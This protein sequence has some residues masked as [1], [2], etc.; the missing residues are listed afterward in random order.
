MSSDGCSLTVHERIAS[1]SS[2]PHGF[3]RDGRRVLSQQCWQG[4]RAEGTGSELSPAPSTFL[5]RSL[6]VVFLP[7]GSCP[8][9]SEFLLV[10]LGR[11]KAK[12]YQENEPHH[13]H[14]CPQHVL[15]CQ[16]RSTW[17]A[18]GTCQ[19]NPALPEPAWSLCSFC[20]SNSVNK[21]AGKYI[22]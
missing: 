10:F 22:F 21:S 5:S 8:D 13:S 18:H 1:V 3:S 4:L 14:S 6:I 12:I 20:S 7:P 2:F 16:Y 19:R 15:L 9:D 17:K 11:H